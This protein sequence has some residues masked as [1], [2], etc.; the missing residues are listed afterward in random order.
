MR[1]GLAKV[2]KAGKART[3]IKVGKVNKVEKGQR[4]SYK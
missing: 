3:V 2:K 4:V 1:R